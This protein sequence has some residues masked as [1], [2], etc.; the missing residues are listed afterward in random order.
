MSVIALITLCAFIG[1]HIQ[2]PHKFV[3]FLEGE[4][5]SFIFMSF[6]PQCS[7]CITNLIFLEQLETVG[8]LQFGDDLNS[9][10]SVSE[11]S[12]MQAG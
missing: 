11:T 10:K 2:F 12:Q 6:H 3:S 9:L 5:V 4:P 1:L 7:V 8:S